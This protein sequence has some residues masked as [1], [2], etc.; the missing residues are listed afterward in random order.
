MADNIAGYE[1]NRKNVE[2][3]REV[4]LTRNTTTNKDNLDVSV[5][6]TSSD[7]VNVNLTSIILTTFNVINVTSPAGAL[8]EF[9]Q[10]ITN[11]TKRL[12]IKARD[13][14]EIR[15]AFGVG[16]TATDYVSIPSGTEWS[17]DNLD[18]NGVTIYLATSVGSRIVEITEGS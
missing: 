12:E 13:N 18:L 10:A 1:T 14:I 2:E 17:Q 8:T 11:G 7:P 15:L 9:S 4:T 5:N 6:N 16:E 3:I